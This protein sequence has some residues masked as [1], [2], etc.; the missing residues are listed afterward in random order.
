MCGLNLVPAK[1]Q[2]FLGPA[3]FSDHLARYSEKSAEAIGY[4]KRARRATSTSNCY[5]TLSFFRHL[6]LAVPGI[7]TADACL[8]SVFLYDG[9]ELQNLALLER[10]SLV[11]CLGRRL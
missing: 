6:L 3:D 4:L 10:V 7:P 11:V 9:Q 8:S 5:S 2:G 1:F